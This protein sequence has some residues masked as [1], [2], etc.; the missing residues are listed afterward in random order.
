[1]GINLPFS[2]SNPIEFA[3][4]HNQD[5]TRGIKKIA[6]YHTNPRQIKTEL[7]PVLLQIEPKN[8]IVF[9]ENFYTIDNTSDFLPNPVKQVKL[10]ITSITK[11][12]SFGEDS[13]SFCDE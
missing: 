12:I 13:Q 4:K 8:E 6:D 5:S 3:L 7:S 10:K 1:M 2:G 9:S 11:G